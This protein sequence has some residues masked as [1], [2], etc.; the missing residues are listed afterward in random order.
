[1]II[2]LAVTA[3]QGRAAVTISMFICMFICIYVGILLDKKF[4]T[5]LSSM[6]VL[7]VRGINRPQMKMSFLSSLTLLVDDRK[8]IW[9]IR[10]LPLLFWKKW[11][12]KLNEVRI[13]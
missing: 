5:V 7:V 3:R 13:S 11:R 6:S 4:P 9:S 1:M 8:S 12:K 10:K 2:L